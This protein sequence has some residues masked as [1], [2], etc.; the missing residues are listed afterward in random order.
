MSGRAAEP[1]GGRRRRGLVVLRSFGKFFGLAGVRLGFAL[2]S[3]GRSPRR[4][5]G[6]LG[7]WAVR[8]PALDYGLTGAR[9]SRLAAGDARAARVGGRRLDALFAAA[10]HCRH[11]GTGAVPF[12]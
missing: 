6:E 3:A 9:R 7:P 12:R 2:A 8:G 5:D 10:R 11:G 1:G 4:L